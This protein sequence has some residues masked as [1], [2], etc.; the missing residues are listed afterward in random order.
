[1]RIANP[2]IQI[3]LAAFLAAGCALSLHATTLSYADFSSVAGLQ[4]NG[5]AAQVG[6]V[7]R[8]TPANYNQ[9]GSVFSTAPVTLGGDVSFSTYFQFRITDS[10]GINDGVVGADGLVFVV[11]TVSNTAGGAG[12]GIGYSGLKPS[13][14]VEFDT[15]NNGGWDDNNGNHIGVDINGEI[16]SVSQVAYPT[17]MNNGQVWNAWVD[18][19]GVA[20]SLEVRLS[21]SAMRPTGADLAYNVDLAAVIGTDVFVGFTSGTGSAY[22]NH[23]VLSWEF[24]DT[25]Q[26]VQVPEG[27]CILLL[28]GMASAGLS[29]LRKR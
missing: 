21:D 4:I 23:D 12:G 8:V 18:Y 25:Y 26:P 2:I 28:I 13:V 15:W 29:L 6:N 14:G 10:G 20:H 5:N 9:S 19:N 16:D 3:P 22:G 7:L 27:G 11:Q 24:R 17:T 1:M